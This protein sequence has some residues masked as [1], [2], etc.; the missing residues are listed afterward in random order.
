MKFFNTTFLVSIVS[1]SLSGCVTDVESTPPG[2][3]PGQLNSSEGP[4][5]APDWLT[6]N[7]YDTTATISF[8]TCNPQN[9]NEGDVATCS[10]QIPPT[11]VTNIPNEED[12]KLYDVTYK[13]RAPTTRVTENLA[14]EFLNE[15]SKTGQET[16]QIK[17]RATA[18]AYVGPVDSMGARVASPVYLESVG[19]YVSHK[20]WPGN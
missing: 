13:H 7:G 3:G 8:L 15:P 12:G 16:W 11:T 20:L 14:V 1:L 9:L 18:T 2:S 10:V 6:R 19:D 17:I 4:G 5:A